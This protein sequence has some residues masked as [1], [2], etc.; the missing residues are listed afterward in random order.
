MNDKGIQ[1]LEQYNLEIMRTLKG[2][3]TWIAETDQGYYRL[4]EYKGSIK[5]LIYENELLCYIQA[6]GGIVTDSILKNKE[7]EL[8]SVDG[9]GEKYVLVKHFNGNECDVRSREDV[10][11]AVKTL[12]RLHR[13]MEHVPFECVEYI[14]ILNSCL[15]EVKKHNRELARIRNFIRNRTKKTQFEYDVLAYFDEFYTQAKDAEQRLEL[16]G[17][18]KIYQKAIAQCSICH[19]NFNYHNLVKEG[20]QMAVLN[21]E[22]SGRGIL[23]RDFVFF[24]RKI[25][26]KN[27]WNEKYGMELIEAYD[28]IRTIS[29]EEGKI[30]TILTEYPEKF[31]KLLNHYYNSN[32]AYFP[33]QMRDKMRKVWGQQENKNKFVKSIN[34]D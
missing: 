22:H 32:K 18:E 24:L 16:V 13:I 15:E 29:E 11:E 25:M 3:G 19:G 7:D 2:R 23:I 26:E 1:V 14:P 8:F 28:T 30:L 12:A 33:D 34:L 10:K 6:Q 27:D 4:L 20:K 21:F 31:W 17:C 9:Y 5:R